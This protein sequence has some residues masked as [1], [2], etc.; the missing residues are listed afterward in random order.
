MEGG[1]D[2]CLSYSLQAAYNKAD[3][4]RSPYYREKFEALASV[5]EGFRQEGVRWA[6]S[7]SA[8]LFVRGITDDF[9]DFDLL[10][11]KE[12]VDKAKK[13]L[14]ECGVEV[15]EETPQRHQF[16]ASPYY[17]QAKKGAVEFDLIADISVRTFGGLYTYKVEQGVEVDSLEGNIAIPLCPIEAQLVLYG[18]ME[19]WQARRRY[20]RE[21]CHEYLT[22][23]RKKQHPLRYSF[24]LEDAL[25][26]QIPPF[27]KEVIQ[28]LL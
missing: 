26:Q 17:Q 13:V 21:L 16:F 2:M 1:I 18:M 15:D 20:K 28:A 4:T 19:G 27:L 6:L 24:I 9:D 22:E 12:D 10:L 7:C 8:A 25:Q 23:M 11:H 14:A 3:L 5:S